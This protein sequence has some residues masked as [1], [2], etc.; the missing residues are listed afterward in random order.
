MVTF[1][2]ILGGDKAVYAIYASVEFKF[3]QCNLPATQDVLSDD[4][5]VRQ[6]MP[7]N[8]HLKRPN[9]NLQLTDLFSA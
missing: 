6:A 7:K 2:V 8:A 9:F 1:N 4:L 3:C 5:G